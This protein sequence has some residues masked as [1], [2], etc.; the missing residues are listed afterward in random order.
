MAFK[1]RRLKIRE[2]QEI[3]RRSTIKQIFQQA[4]I[5]F[6]AG[7]R[8]FR[9]NILHPIRNLKIAFGMLEDETLNELLKKTHHKDKEHAVHMP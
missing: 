1:R 3:Q 4:A 2:R 7:V 6:R 5:G 8:D 9:R